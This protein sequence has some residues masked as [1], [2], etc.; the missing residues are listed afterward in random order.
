MDHEGTKHTQLINSMKEIKADVLGIQEHN[1]NL[2]SMTGRSK[3]DNRFR[4]WSRIHT[5]ASWN[6]HTKSKERHLFGGTAMFVGSDHAH[7]VVIHGGDDRGLGRWSWV[8]LQGQ[9]GR[10][11]RIISA[12]RPVTDSSNRPTSV[13]AQQEAV[14]LTHHD[15]RNPRA[16]VLEDL[17]RHI[18]RWQQEGDWIVLGMDANE[19]I[20][21]GPAG[22]A[23]RC[24]LIS[25][26]ESTHPDLPM[27]STCSKNRQEIAVDGIWCSPGLDIIQCG[28]TGFGEIQIGRTDHRML[29]VDI[30][31]FSAFGYN[32]PAP[33]YRQPNRLVVS[34]PKV[35]QKYNKEAVR[36]H[37]NEDSVTKL[38]GVVQHYNS[39]G[40]KRD[41]TRRYDRLVRS[42][43][44]IRQRAKRRCRKLCMGKVPFS[45]EMQPYQRQI[46]MWNLIRDRRKGLRVDSRKI[47]RLMRQTGIHDAY[48]KNLQQAQRARRAIVKE[49]RQ[50]KS[51][52]E[53]MRTRFRKRVA[54]ARAKKFKTTIQAQ[55]KMIASA[56][57]QK[58]AHQRIG[59]VMKK[60]R[61]AISYVTDGHGD[62]LRHHYKKRAIEQAL[63]KEGSARFTQAYGTDMTI[64]PMVD[65]FPHLGCDNVDMVLQGTRVVMSARPARTSLYR[66]SWH[67]SSSYPAFHWKETLP[68]L[69]ILMTIS[70][71]GNG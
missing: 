24:N 10:R 11:L 34:N 8:V 46:A 19:N 31:K 56:F 35:V 5:N 50:M 48:T 63:E 20:T 61:T 54:A 26:M 22:F 2:Q 49:Y 44:K 53:E 29:W 15:E 32:P 9:H 1:L 38:V 40:N 65:D 51:K 33:A 60:Q 39:T 43:F 45:D 66:N 4:K 27:V 17:Q 64:P 37:D 41:T 42:D 36:L 12:Y 16:A 6:I 69:S 57:R 71:D 47:R 30:S 28:M 52:A 23:R 21:R 13:F 18:I 14:L 67:N 62:G 25:V 70:R 68:P 58:Q 3:W 59:A 55:E 7:K